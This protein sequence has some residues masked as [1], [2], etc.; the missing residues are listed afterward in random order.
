M[1]KR[2]VTLYKNSQTAGCAAGEEY[3]DRWELSPY[4]APTMFHE[5]KTSGR[6][7]FTVPD[8]YTIEGGNFLKEGRDICIVIRGPDGRLRLTAKNY[9]DAGAPLYGVDETAAEEE[10][11]GTRRNGKARSMF[12]YIPRTVNGELEIF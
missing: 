4:A 12:D 11:A 8:G 9:P 10:S 3:T 7:E 2:T 5:G 6:R 1:K